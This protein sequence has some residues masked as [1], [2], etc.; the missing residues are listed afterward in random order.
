MVC[1]GI[2]MYEGL[3]YGNEITVYPQMNLNE[4]ATNVKFFVEW[5]KYIQ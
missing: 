3:C 1:I 5:P 2:A 4:L